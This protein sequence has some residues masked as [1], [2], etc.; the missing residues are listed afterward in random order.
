M[1]SEEDLI[2]I[3]A[4]Q[5]IAYCERRFYLILVE[6]I[7]VDNVF[8]AE[9]T[10]LHEIAHQESS[11]SRNELYIARSLYL[12]SFHYGICGKADIVEFLKVKKDSDNPSTVCLD[13]L[14]GRWIPYPVEYKRGI[15][16]HEET[17]EIQLCAQ[18][19]CLEEMLKTNIQAGSIYYG[20]SKKRVNVQFSE[21]LRC[22]TILGIAK[23]REII[24]TSAIPKA[25]Y[26]PKCPK[27]SLIE[28]C[29]PKL[30]NKR[31]SAKKYLNVAISNSN[32]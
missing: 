24:N 16:R 15:Q 10:V 20:K 12:R 29:L 3:S 21:V 1:F 8:T 26:G 11:E 7:W 28:Q 32:K 13:S 18:T 31:Y 4:L 30:T 19:L 6:H 17:F 5:H 23:A 14:N 9:G 27:C 22:K 25:I 2:S